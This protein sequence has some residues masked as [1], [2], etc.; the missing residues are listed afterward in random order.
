MLVK[1]PAQIGSRG[2]LF[3]SKMASQRML[4]RQCFFAQV[5][6]ETKLLGEGAV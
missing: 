5:V 1:A 4:G 6:F 3:R 2:G